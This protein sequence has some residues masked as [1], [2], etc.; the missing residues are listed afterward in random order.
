[1]SGREGDSGSSLTKGKEIDRSLSIGSRVAQIL[2]LSGYEVTHDYSRS[3]SAIMFDIFAENEVGKRIIVKCHGLPRPVETKDVSLFAEEVRD[4]FP[5]FFIDFDDC[6]AWY[7]TIGDF[8]QSARELCEEQ[9]I[10]PVNRDGLK[11]LEDRVI[12]GY[13]LEFDER[14][15]EDVKNKYIEQLVTLPN[16]IRVDTEK[17]EGKKTIKVFVTRKI[18]ESELQP[19]EVVPKALGGYETDVEEIGS[20]ELAAVQSIE[21]QRFLKGIPPEDRST[22]LLEGIDIEKFLFLEERNRLSAKAL[23][24][25]S[26]SDEDLGFLAKLTYEV[27]HTVLNQF[28]DQKGRAERRIDKSIQAMKLAFRLTLVMHNVMFYLG[29]ALVVIGV[30]SAF[31]G[32]SLEGITLGGVG[33]FDIIFYLIRKPIEGIHESTGNLMQLRAA[34]NSFFMLL[35][36]WDVQEHFWLYIG[37]ASEDHFGRVRRISKTFQQHTGDTLDLISQYCKPRSNQEGT[38]VERNGS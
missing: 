23:N 33:L 28:R 4:V 11:E 7:V 1:M 17:K 8:D 9:R 19:K 20:E 18:P 6:P 38:E 29:V 12:R 30:I 36:Q 14:N 16:V 13:R 37:Y 27:R 31:S 24:L 2:R 26:F 35:K 5:G 21:L 25:K 22:D 10:L 34:Y 32:R 15:I 3:G